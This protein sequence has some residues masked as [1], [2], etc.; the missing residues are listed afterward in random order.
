MKC[1]ICKKETEKSHDGVPVC[2]DC[3][4]KKVKENG[5]KFAPDFHK[6]IKPAVK[7]KKKRSGK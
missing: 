4:V 3:F 1:V 2:H 5:G 7:S 6:Y